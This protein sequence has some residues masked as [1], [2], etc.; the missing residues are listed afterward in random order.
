[1]QPKILALRAISA[2]YVKDIL[3]PIFFIVISVLLLLM[4]GV[5][6][7]ANAWSLWWLIFLLPLVLMTSVTIVLAVVTLYIAR[8]VTP[9]MTKT[10]KNAV[11]SYVQNI[12]DVSEVTRTPRFEVAFKVIIDVCRRRWKDGYLH[13]TATKSASLKKDFESIVDSFS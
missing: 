8:I 7:A 9:S 12:H 4:V 10:Q 3:K 5:V 11:R 1:M 6:Y 2:Q 13:Q